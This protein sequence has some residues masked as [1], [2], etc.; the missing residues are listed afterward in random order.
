MSRRLALVLLALPLAAACAKP[1][2]RLYPNAHLERVG[3]AAAER[4]IAQC[5]ALADAA[6]LESSRAGRAAGNTAAGAAGGAAVGA[7]VGAISGNAG[8]GAATGAAGGGV[9]G[10][11]RGLFGQRGPDPLYRRYVDICLQERG[12]R[13]LGWK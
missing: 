9:A 13:T 8:R 5:R 4:D 7:A 1:G 2:P 12:Y 6:D 3:P 11:I 10:L